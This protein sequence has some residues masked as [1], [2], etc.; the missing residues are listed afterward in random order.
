MVTK[1][2]QAESVAQ[3]AE[4]PK[5]TEGEVLDVSSMLKSYDAEAIQPQS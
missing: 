3:A 5:K 2:T 4:E 1:K